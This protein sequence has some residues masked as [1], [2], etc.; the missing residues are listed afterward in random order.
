MVDHVLADVTELASRSLL[1]H[2]DQASTF[3]FGSTK[4]G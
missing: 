4:S 2:A 1:G 3:G